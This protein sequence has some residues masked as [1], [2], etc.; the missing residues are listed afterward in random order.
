ML[1]VI[2]EGSN[3]ISEILIDAYKLKVKIIKQKSKKG[4]SFI[5]KNILNTVANQ[6]KAK[7]KE[8]RKN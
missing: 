4:I 6:I 5:A 1:D 3:G 2:I 8:L 7:I